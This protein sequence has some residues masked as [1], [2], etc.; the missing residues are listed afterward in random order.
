MRKIIERSEIPYKIFLSLRDFKT[1]YFRV[2]FGVH[3]QHR[4]VQERAAGAGRPSQPHT[5]PRRNRLHR[6]N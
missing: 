5:V 6:R 3:S 1:M 4:G 2:G